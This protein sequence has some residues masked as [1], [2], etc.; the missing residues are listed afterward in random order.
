[1]EFQNYIFE[2]E[3]LL[4]DNLLEA[5]YGSELLVVRCRGHKLSKNC[6]AS[7]HNLA[8]DISWPSLI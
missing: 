3:M 1:M 8:A 6:T 5:R 7:R 4:E 2:I